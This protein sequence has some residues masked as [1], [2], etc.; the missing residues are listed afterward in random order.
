MVRALLHRLRRQR[1]RQRGVAMLIV[2]ISITLLT[3]AG[4]DFAFN[5]RVD[6]QLAANHRD[7]TRAYFLAR[8]GIG[9]SRLVLRFQ[10]QLDT[11]PIPGL[12]GALQGLMPPGQAGAAQAATPSLQVWRLVRVDCHML[13]GMVA[14]S[15][16]GRDSPQP[17]LSESEF[18]REFTEVAQRQALRSF[19]GFDGCFQS[20]ISDEEERINITRLN[21]LSQQAAPTLATLMQLLS[22]R[23]FEFLFAREDANRVKVTP[24]DVV[25][26]LKDWMD[27]DETQ[28]ALNLNDPV[29]PFVNG[30]SDENYNYD[31]YE[32]SYETK[33]ARFDSLDELYLV[34]GINDAFMAAFRD[35]LTVYPDPNQGL[36]VN[37]RDPVLTYAAILS[38]VDPNRPDPRLQDP[39]F[40]D[41]LIQQIEAARMFAYLGM[42]VRDFANVLVAAGV[43]VDP[44]V[45]NN[46]AAN[47]RVSDKSSTYRIESYGEVGNVMKKITAVVR[48]DDGL[49][50]LVYWR[51][52]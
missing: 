9:L 49:G 42:T 7:D 21:G 11:T 19:G 4:A 23:R 8:S 39:I 43:A 13:R 26:G 2:V 48:L 36:N 37:S 15:E 51:E 20:K 32:P 14:D 50:R 41:Q 10:R 34:H 40:V 52:E 31:R 35:R 17:A 46:P 22:D 38:I 16:S 30:F 18:D 12:G 3:I 29:N 45:I 1:S 44:R 28:S 25:I 6:L 33:N 24:Q 27:E 5:T 47:N